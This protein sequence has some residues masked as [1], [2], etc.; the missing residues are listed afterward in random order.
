MGWLSSYGETNKIVDET[1]ARKQTIIFA[2]G[3]GLILTRTITETRYRYV[4]MTMAAA[5]SA[6]TA[7]EASAPE[8][9]ERTASRRRQ[10]DADA[11]Q[12]EVCDI[13][14]GAWTNPEETPP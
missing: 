12:V 10:N 13:V 3:A 9:T 5:D 7:L 6:V 14:T 2:F 1:H 11:Y 8:N 4:G